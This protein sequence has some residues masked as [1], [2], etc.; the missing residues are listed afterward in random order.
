VTF[1][2][3]VAVDAN[4]EALAFVDS[5][6]KGGVMD[7]LTRYLTAKKLKVDVGGPWTDVKLLSPRGLRSSTYEKHDAAGKPFKATTYYLTAPAPKI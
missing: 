7:Q 1:V 5:S 4:G 3:V 2:E 6:Q